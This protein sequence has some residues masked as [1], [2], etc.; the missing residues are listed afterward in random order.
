M[1]LLTP[2]INHSIAESPAFA[3]DSFSSPASLLQQLAAVDIRR[4]SRQRI[5]SLGNEMW[6]EILCQ[7]ETFRRT[8]EPD[9]FHARW[10]CGCALRMSNQLFLRFDKAGYHTISYCY[11]CWLLKRNRL[12][13]DTLLFCRYY[14][15]EMKY[16][17]KASAVTM[18]KV[19]VR[20]IKVSARFYDI[21][22]TYAGKSR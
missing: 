3:S 11:Y 16:V 15:I 6:L 4:H 14:R 7:R 19:D 18:I 8:C 20:N 1:I 17:F 10:T 12:R 5:G 13:N 2:L 9:A 22:A 21:D